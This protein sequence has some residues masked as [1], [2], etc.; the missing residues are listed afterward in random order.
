M[1]RPTWSSEAEMLDAFLVQAKAAGWEVY[2]ETSGFDALLV[3]P[4]DV[5]E[6]FVPGDQIAVEAK[7][8]PSVKLLAQVMPPAELSER[9]AADFY[10]VVVPHR[11]GSL[12]DLIDVAH[13]LGV[14]VIAD[15]PQHGDYYRAAFASPGARPFGGA[16]LILWQ[17]YPRIGPQ[18]WTPGAPVDTPAGVPSPSSVTPW[19]WAAVKL[20][21]ELDGLRI[22]TEHFDRRGVSF[23]RWLREG[24]VRQVDI[25]GRRHVYEITDD[26]GR[27]DRRW[28]E[29][30]EALRASGQLSPP[31][32]QGHLFD[33]EVIARQQPAGLEPQRPA[34][35]GLFGGGRG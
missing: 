20:C 24:W 35:A 31:E 29:V 23:P 18:L 4:D 9:P 15:N 6:P 27:P 3:A 13:R 26:P 25:L 17:R 11:R 19:K 21:L 34:Q 2:P 30:V 32:D 1:S 12:R 33:G 7:L 22:T 8:R 14:A 28:P 16:Q 5:A 10:V